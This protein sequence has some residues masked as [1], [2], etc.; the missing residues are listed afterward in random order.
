VADIKFVDAFLDRHAAPRRAGRSPRDGML[1]PKRPRAN[2]AGQALPQS[3][4]GGSD[5]FAARLSSLNFSK[6]RSR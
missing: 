4:M 2:D 5:G 3:S 6:S 1:V